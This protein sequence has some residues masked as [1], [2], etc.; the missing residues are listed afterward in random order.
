MWFTLYV[1]ENW[2]SNGMVLDYKNSYGEM[3]PIL[4]LLK[5][6]INCSILSKYN[7]HDFLLKYF[8]R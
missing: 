1:K 6:F 5:H 7:S 4:V 8:R 2:V 3:L